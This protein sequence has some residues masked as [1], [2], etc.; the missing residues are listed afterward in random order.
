MFGIRFNDNSD[1]VIRAVKGASKAAARQIQGKIVNHARS[2]VM[3]ARGP[4][5]G[6]W[7][8]D[9]LITLRDSI[10]GEVFDGDRG[11]AVRVGSNVQIA[12]YIELGTARLYDPPPEWEEYHNRF[13]DKHSKAGL[14]EWWYFDEAD[15]SFR[16]GKPV[17]SQPYLR[18]AILDHAEEYKQILND[19]LR[20]Q[21]RSGLKG[22]ILD[23]I[24]PID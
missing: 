21:E 4:M 1:D 9:D 12:P 23:A 14:S 6:A 19:S 17:P 10:T 13:G 20:A 11:P 3:K 15:Q 2:A 16:I 18:P 24:D 5:G 8:E 7:R 22:R